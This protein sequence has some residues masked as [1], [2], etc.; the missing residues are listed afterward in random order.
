MTSTDGI[1]LADDIPEASLQ[2]S[3]VRSR[4][5]VGSRDLAL[6]RGPFGSEVVLAGRARSQQLEAISSRRVRGR[7][8]DVQLKAR[9]G[10]KLH[11][12]EVEV[13]LTDGGVAQALSAGP[14]EARVLGCP[15][16]PEKLA[17]R[18]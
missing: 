10:G 13:E 3:H 5:R 9:L 18:G 7:G 1:P 12:L 6:R 17:A 4:N 15:L 14:V 11:R 8:V 16:L 2:P